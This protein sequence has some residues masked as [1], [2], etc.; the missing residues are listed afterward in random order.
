[1]P[2]W[3]R[4]PVASYT[5]TIAKATAGATNP[6]FGVITSFEP[7]A[8]AFGATA[9][10]NL[11]IIYRVAST[12]M[13]ANV[14]VDPTVLY[15]IQGDSAGAIAATA[16]GSN[17]N[18]VFTHAGDTMTGLSGMEAN[19]A[20]IAVTSTY[21]LKLIRAA[22]I[23][24]NDISLANAI[25]VVLP[26]EREIHA[27][28]ASGMVVSSLGPDKIDSAGKGFIP[29]KMDLAPDGRLV[30][31][32]ARNGMVACFNRK[33]DLLWS[34]RLDSPS[35]DEKSVWEG[36]PPGMKGLS[37][38]PSSVLVF[39]GEI[40]VTDQRLQLIY[41]LSMEGDLRGYITHYRKGG[42]T[43]RLRRV[44]E[45][46]AAGGKRLFPCKACA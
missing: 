1:M 22:D 37:P 26:R 35:P 15:E 40:W 6:I 7:V 31:S 4:I 12:A 43:W 9:N 11:Q 32:D 33:G 23:P 39:P 5:T 41:R 3:R 2:A 27:M 13:Y 34:R 19:S 46:V 17:I 30:V 8:P 18:L 29:H 38:T 42:D 25:W 24:T 36:F 10:L 20:A 28:N 21:Q 44:G 45:L 14:C 16:L